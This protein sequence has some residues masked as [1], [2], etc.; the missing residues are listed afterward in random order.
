MEGNSTVTEKLEPKLSDSAESLPSGGPHSIESRIDQ[1]DLKMV[2]MVMKMSQAVS[3][4]I[5]LERVAEAVTRFAIE[6]GGAERALLILRRGEEYWIEAEAEISVNGIEVQLERAAASSSELPESLLRYVI[7]SR[8]SL[9]LDDASNDRFFSQDPYILEK[10]LRSV[11]FLPLVKRTE[12]MGTLYLENKLWTRFFTPK[13]LALLELL[14]AEA[15][16]SLDHACLYAAAKRAEEMNVA[17]ARERETFAQQRVA[18]LAKANAA[19]RDS[20]DQLASV[21]QLDEFIGQVMA[22]ITGQL[23]AVSSS[24][25]LFGPDE[26]TMRLELIY[27]G[28]RVRSLDE[29]GYPNSIRSIK[30]GDLMASGLVASI[31]LLPLDRPTALPEGVRTYLAG[32]GIKSVL[33]IPLSSKGHINGMLSFRFIN[34]RAFQEEELEIARALATQASLAIQLT[35]LA[36]G[37]RESAV[38]EERNRLASEIH[39]SLAQSF[40]GISMQLSAA[41]RAMLKKSKDA[42]QHVERANEL[43]RFGLSEAR[44]SALSLRSNI[45]EES[46]LI[47]ALRKLAERSSI[48]GLITCSFQASRVDEKA[49]S[50]QIQQDLLRIGQEAIS[51][52][53]RHAQPTEIRVSLRVNPRNLVLKVTDNGSGLAKARLVSGGQGFGFANMRE[54]A[55]NLGATLD[56]R[57]KPGDGTSVIVRLANSSEARSNSKQ[58][59]PC[60]P[61][62]GQKS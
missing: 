26:Q 1:L 38:L 59:N 15:T 33:I 35:R 43:A 52:A 12:L 13:R 32:L 18:Q 10:Q 4:E 19:L 40:A 62:A 44:R 3:S 51:N 23:G 56:I 47:E 34:E 41:G 27:E 25:S 7:R 24:L 42:Q 17:M 53:L 55:K 22:A 58:Q 14:T 30:R 2:K 45:I 54:R 11:L 39:D 60:C 20:L 5:A 49:L 48:P 9:I 46:G 36:K 16:I 28:G 31:A 29:I 61:A 50:P 8:R 37:A 21:P 57:S 6:Y